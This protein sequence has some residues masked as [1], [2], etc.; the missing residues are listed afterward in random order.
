M[1]VKIT[2]LMP[3]SE[4]S[5]EQLSG[6]VIAIDAP[7][8]LYQFLT[9][10]MQRD[11]TPL[12]DSKGNVTSHLTG[13]FSRTIRLI[14]AGLK[15]VYVFDGVPPIL[16]KQER[17]KRKAAKIEAE[18]Q[19]EAAAEA[20]DTESM[21]KYA[22]RTTRLTPGMITEAKKLIAALG[23]PI[24]QAPSEGE[25]QAAFLVKKGEAFCVASQDADCLL[26]GAGRLVRNLGITGR[27]KKPNQLVYKS[28]QPELISLDET[29]KSLG[30]NQAQLIALGMLVGT[31]YNP[32][33]VF[34]IGQK[35]ALKLVK[36][37]GENLDGLF[38][39]VDWGNGFETPW[40]EVYDL[41]EKMPVTGEYSLRWSP[42][43]KEAIIKLLCGEHDFS[44]E[45]IEKSI[46][47]MPKGLGQKSL[48]EFR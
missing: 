40:Q 3:K 26:F 19:Y 12:L 21:K 7:N 15:P 41:F 45:R 14:S 17:E 44:V 37:F 23:L 8:H 46:D 4:V 35:K 2:E 29:L 47:S 28:V 39:S 30:I 6:K 20:G 1:G 22:A 33:G 5:L 13:L 9:T 16:K 32:G 42:P 18:R 34:G 36:E 25:A 27:R 38:K 48:F 43:N 11:G 10:I 31:D 24:I